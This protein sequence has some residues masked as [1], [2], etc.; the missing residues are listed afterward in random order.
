[1]SGTM[2][3]PGLIFQVFHGCQTHVQ[4]KDASREFKV[5][6]FFFTFMFGFFL[7]LIP[8]I[9]ILSSLISFFYMFIVSWNKYYLLL[10]A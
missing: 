2:T 3:L 7:H 5:N 8:K 6:L 10:I 4:A 9:Q 1:M